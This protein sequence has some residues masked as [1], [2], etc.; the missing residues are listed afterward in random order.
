MNRRSWLVLAT[1]PLLYPV[2][3]C[4]AQSSLPEEYLGQWY[5]SG[6]SGG[7]DGNGTG[8]PAVGWI[9]IT[10]DNEIEHYRDDGSLAVTTRFDLT[11]AQSIYTGQE[12][13]ALSESGGMQRVIALYENGTMAISDNVY[14]GYSS[15]Y[16]RTPL[17]R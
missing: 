3:G 8:E 9:V 6:S 10:D 2:M 14:D 11:R 17:T 1:F 16:Q 7:M 13:W 15:G 12:A 4:Q 5:F